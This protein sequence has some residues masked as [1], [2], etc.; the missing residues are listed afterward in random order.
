MEQQDEVMRWFVMR[1]LKRVNAKNHAYKMLQ[2]LKFEVFTPMKWHVVTRKGEKVREEIPVIPDLLFVRSTR[3]DLDPIV[4]KT[5]TLQYRFLR[6]T[7]CEPM[8]VRDSD[9]ERFIHAVN[10]SESVKYYLLEELSPEMYNKKIRI[11]GGKLDGYEGMLLTVRGSKTKRL[12]V[13]LPGMLAV[14]VE[15]SPEYIQLI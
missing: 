9:M 11:I 7:W 15:V 2:G 1:D 4:E 6:R 8:T 12:L 5:E 10:S 3:A 14:G 13:E